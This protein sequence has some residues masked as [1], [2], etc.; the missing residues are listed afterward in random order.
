MAARLDGRTRELVA[1]VFYEDHLARTGAGEAAWDALAPDEQDPYL[2]RA[3]DV[4]AKV[5]LIGATVAKDGP[6]TRGRRDAPESDG[7]LFTPEELELLS[8]HEHERWMEEKLDTGWRLG[9]EVDA[10]SRTHPSLVDYDLLPV[11][12]KV[13]DT[14]VVARIPALLR[15]AGLRI[16]RT[17]TG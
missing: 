5:E 17:R 15:A 12:E 7:F 16:V 10:A 14:E 13:K 4:A 8:R 11:E 6:A 3:D 9:P 2:R 1:R